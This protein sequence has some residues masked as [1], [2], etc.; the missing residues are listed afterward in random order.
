METTTLTMVRAEARALYRQYRK[1]LHWSTPIDH[2]IARIYQ[3]LAQG[4]VIV[5]ALESITTAGLGE[6]KRPKLAIVRADAQRCFVRGWGGAV[7]FSMKAWAYDNQTRTYIDIP[8]DRF[9]GPVASG[10]AIVPLVPLPHR[11]PRGL[12]NYHILF[13]AEWR[14]VPPTD[15]MLLRRLGKADLWVVV[16]AWDLTEI[17]R[18]VLAARISA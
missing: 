18:T 6:D 15:P 16:A 10:E 2:E 4:R 5:K 9:A 8:G 13:E 14:N 3:L 11:P 7:R 17:E 1:H 12:A